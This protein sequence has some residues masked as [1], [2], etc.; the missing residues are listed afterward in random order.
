ME[1]IFFLI[2]AIMAI[3]SAIGVVSLRNPVHSAIS[4]MACFFQ[5]AAIFV[6]LR[7]PFLAAVQV[8]LYVGAVMVLFL[9]VIMMLDIRKATISRFVP[10][11]LFWIVVILIALVY[12][13]LAVISKS[14]L[15][16]RR[17][18]AVRLD[19]T[20]AEIG[21]TL[22]TEY[23]LPF[24]VVSVILLVALIGAIVMGKKEIK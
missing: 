23:L 8:F 9:F 22:F 2:F 14:N 13:I 6:L 21:K 24:E 5:V 19:G 16:A 1:K 17:V 3:A 18:A 20:V 10:G 15:L 7:S 12:E 11:G 4:L